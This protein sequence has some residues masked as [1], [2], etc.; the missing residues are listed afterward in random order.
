[1]ST[2]WITG[3]DA[4]K[5]PER[6]RLAI[7]DQQDRSE[8]LITYFQL[9]VLVVI[10]TFY[11]LSP[12]TF[13]DEA[14]FEPVPWA[15]GIYLALT[16]IR[17]V[18][19][20]RA[21]L[22]AWSLAIS[23]VFDMGLLMVLIWTFHIQYEQPASFYLKAPTILWIFIFIALR[24]LRFDWRFVALSGAVAVVSWILMVLYVV[25]GDPDDMMIT[26]DYVAYLTSNSVLI[27]AEVE[28]I[29]IISVVTAIIAFA[30]IR[31]RSLLV[32]AV[33]EHTAAEELSRF[34]APEIAAKIKGSE[35]EIHAGTGEMRDAAVLNLDMRGF[36]SFAAE[37]PPDAVMR[38][39]SEYQ[40]QVVPVIQKHGG[41][42]DKFLGDG[43]MA[44]F[45]AAVPSTS[46]A[47]DSLRALEETMAA[48]E[49][50]ANSCAAEGRS[51]PR[52]NGSV[53][54]GKVLFGAVG[55]ETRLEYTV[56]GDAVNLSAKLEKQNKELGVRAVCDRT[57]YDLA[58][59]QGFEDAKGLRQVSGAL[60]AGVDHPVDLVVVAP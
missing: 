53:A 45:G 49:R 32:Q 52:V 48:A 14:A 42:I 41:S 11:F 57:T 44:T 12:K 10:G 13:S 16:L 40:A 51:C 27:G 36:T 55:D 59:E 39:L 50:W 38:L 43:I 17:L 20:A 2:N 15:L 21:R 8:R 56:I 23:V 33:S 4:E 22:P 25:F 30:L 60:V 6:V 5:L 35:H 9:S 24:A 3:D 18:W 7:R 1:M 19:S 34:F 37:A 46:Y 29:L 54:T 47:A 58:V 26:R 28:K 31:A